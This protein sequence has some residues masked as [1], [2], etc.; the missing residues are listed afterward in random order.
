MK[1]K[2]VSEEVDLF[3]KYLQEQTGLSI[4]SIFEYSRTISDYLG[5]I[6]NSES[7]NRDETMRWLSQKVRKK[8]SVVAKYALQHYLFFKKNKDLLDIIRLI[9]FKLPSKLKT[10]QEFDRAAILRAIRNIRH[11]VCRDIARIQAITGARIKEI[12]LLREENVVFNYKRLIK[13]DDGTTYEQQMI[14]VQIVGKGNYT[15]YLFLPVELEQLLKKYVLGFKGYMFL[16]RKKVYDD[17]SFEKKLASVRA[18][19]Y[20]HLNNAMKAE[21][22]EGFGTH[23]LRRNFATTIFN[24]GAQITAVRDLLGHKSVST[25]EIYLPKYGNDTF[26]HLLEFQQKVLKKPKEKVA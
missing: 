2:S 8:H 13:N 3:R 19:Y 17:F 18:I 6:E 11:P 9:H 4:S 22:V 12:L 10:V 21:G 15:R 7:L 23:D 1:N 26:V 25:T 24:Q 16:N 20:R 5:F 14:K